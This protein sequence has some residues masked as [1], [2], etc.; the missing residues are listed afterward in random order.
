[1]KTRRHHHHH[2]HQFGSLHVI[3]FF[4]GKHRP[5][6]VTGRH[7]GWKAPDHAPLQGLQRK[8]PRRAVGVADLVLAVARLQAQLVEEMLRLQCHGPWLVSSGGF[9]VEKPYR[10]M[11]RGSLWLV[12]DG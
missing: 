1:M 4:G 9:Q 6:Q 3:P 8:L 7:Q 10:L 11:T 2:H 12:N 5:D